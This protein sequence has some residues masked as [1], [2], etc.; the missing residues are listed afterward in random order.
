VNDDY[1]YEVKP[2]ATQVIDEIQ[3]RG[4][5]IVLIE[6]TGNTDRVHKAVMGGLYN[7]PY[8]ADT[9]AVMSVK[10]ERELKNE[11]TD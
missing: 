3:A 2:L 8:W 4:N 6:L 9:V 5:S 11:R 10:G 7:S 1:Q